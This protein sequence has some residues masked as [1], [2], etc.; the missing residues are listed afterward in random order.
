MSGSNLR[1]STP[2]IM[3]QQTVGGT[4][5]TEYFPTQTIKLAIFKGIPTTGTF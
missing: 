4:T 2:D 3:H 5:Q 1:G